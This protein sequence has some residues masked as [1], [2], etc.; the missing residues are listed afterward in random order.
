VLFSSP[1]PLERSTN[2]F[3]EF[4]QFFIEVWR[5]LASTMA[6]HWA[7]LTQSLQQPL[8][9]SEFYEK[10]KPSERFSHFR[11]ANYPAC[12]RF[13]LFTIPTLSG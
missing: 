11:L 8:K 3:L 10:V 13:G 7:M 4:V 2:E 12:H 6:R 9:V 5:Q 1:V